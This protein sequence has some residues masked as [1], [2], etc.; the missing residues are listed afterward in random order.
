MGK[1]NLQEKGGG[2]SYDLCHTGIS[3][4][5]QAENGKAC[6]L[7]TLAATLIPGKK[8]KNKIDTLLALL[9]LEQLCALKK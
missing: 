9:L 8:G 1:G 5:K 2:M 7:D 4:I 3:R 6:A